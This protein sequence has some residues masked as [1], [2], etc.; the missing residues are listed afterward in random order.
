MSNSGAS[1]NRVKLVS[2]NRNF[3]DKSIQLLCVSPIPKQPPL[4]AIS[5]SRYDPVMPDKP[6]S[7]LIVD[8]VAD[9]A[10]SL[11]M[12]LELHGYTVRT[13]TNGL[14]ALDAVLADPPNVV[15]T[16]IGMPVLDGW[17]LAREIR[18]KLPGPRPFI[19]ALSGYSQEADKEKSAVS[20]IDLHLPKPVDFE[21]LTNTLR[22]VQQDPRWT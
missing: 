7:I 1:D 14:V 8:D 10:L 15:I 2:G 16:D 9:N 4:L 3:P 11:S 21:R 5:G 13:A 12:V 22:I 18:M 6:L 20:G 19:I 17:N